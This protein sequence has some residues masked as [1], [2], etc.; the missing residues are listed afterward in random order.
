MNHE[1]MKK[2]LVEIRQAWGDGL[3]KMWVLQ[4]QDAPD[5][6]IRAVSQGLQDLEEELQNILNLI[7]D[8][9]YPDDLYKVYIQ[10]AT[11]VRF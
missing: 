8:E 9:N 1:E 2:R 7:Q 5:K 10:T 4:K 11:V 6:Q 3:D